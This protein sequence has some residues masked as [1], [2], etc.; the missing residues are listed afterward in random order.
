MG[1]LCAVIELE[2]QVERQR[3]RIISP[4]QRRRRAH[5]RGARGRYVAVALAASRHSATGG[6]LRPASQVVSPLAFRVA[7]TRRELKRNKE[8]RKEQLG[9]MEAA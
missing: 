3:L 5:P 2:T 6:A 9:Q 7:G 1:T 8:Q 4:C